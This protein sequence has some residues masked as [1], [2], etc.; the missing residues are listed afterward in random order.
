ML[1]GNFL[2]DAIPLIVIHLL[3]HHCNMLCAEPSAPDTRGMAREIH[4]NL[5]KRRHFLEGLDLI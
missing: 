4:L 5:K 1:A 2:V 3:I